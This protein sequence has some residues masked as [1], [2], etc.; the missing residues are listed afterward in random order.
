MT[1]CCE[2]MKNS[3][4]PNN[5]ISPWSYN[6]RQRS[7]YI[8]SVNHPGSSLAYY[9]AFCGT[10]FP[11]PLNDEWFRVLR[12]EYGFSNP[13]QARREKLIPVEFQTDEW[14]RKRGL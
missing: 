13:G 8:K 4:D 3:V 12:E 10:K 14:W 6:E 11:E 1:H 5:E 9:C 7:Y 2:R